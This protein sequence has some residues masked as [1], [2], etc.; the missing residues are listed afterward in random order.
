LLTPLFIIHFFASGAIIS[1]KIGVLTNLGLSTYIFPS[2]VLTVNQIANGAIIENKFASN[3]IF[4]SLISFGAVTNNKVAP[5]SIGTNEI[6]DGSI[7]LIRVVPNTI[8][9]N[10]FMPSGFDQTVFSSWTNFKNKIRL[11]TTS[12][13]EPTT[14]CGSL[15]VAYRTFGTEMCMWDCNASTKFC[16]PLVNTN[17]YF[18]WINFNT[19]PN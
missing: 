13:V 18:N 14:G 1:N 5:N 2:G 4:T 12:G 10:L 3:S 7:D 9:S 16:A 11:G 8:T 15:Y 17:I 6:N 19:I